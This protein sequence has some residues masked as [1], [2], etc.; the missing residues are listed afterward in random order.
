MKGRLIFAWIVPIYVVVGTAC[1][2]PCNEL[3]AKV[4]DDPKYVRANKRHCEL[5]RDT[6][7]R[8]NLTKDACRGLLDY[9]AK[10]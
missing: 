1:S 5:I 10:R 3:E 7:R 2:D 9:L 4:C 8:E 6:E